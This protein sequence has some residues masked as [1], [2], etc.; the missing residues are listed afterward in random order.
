[1]FLETAGE[2]D[3]CGEGDGVGGIVNSVEAT[4]SILTMSA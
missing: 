2:R 4:H 1:M 3:D